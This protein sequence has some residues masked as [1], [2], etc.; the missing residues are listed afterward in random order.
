MRKS[1]LLAAS[2]TVA[3]AGCSQGTEAP[4]VATLAS[5]APTVKA[6]QAQSTSVTPAQDQRPQLRLDTSEAE[7]QRLFAAYDD[8]LVGHGVKV[9]AV[10][11]AAPAGAKRRLDDSGEPKSAYLACANKL[12]QQPREL[13]PD[14]NPKFAE[15]WNDNVRCLRKHGIKVHVTAPGEWTYDDSDFVIPPNQDQIEQQCVQEAFG[16]GH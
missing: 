12:P 1:L 5:A 11:E 16:A 2:L 15:Q 14:A 13:D 6:G 10:R 4:G 3:L 8:C 7:R 9:V